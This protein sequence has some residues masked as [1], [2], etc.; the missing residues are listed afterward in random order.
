MR[1]AVIPLCL[2]FDLASNAAFSQ[3]NNEPGSHLH[4]C[5]LMGPTERVECLNKL[6]QSISPPAPASHWT[7]SETISPLDYTP[8]VL[9]VTSSR[10]ASSS[11]QLSLSCRGGRTEFVIAG[12][13]I[14]RTEDYTVSYRINDGGSVTTAVGKPIFGTR[15]AFKTDVV[16]LL[17]SLPDEGYISVR[18]TPR[19]GPAS[20]GQFSLSGSKVVRDKLAA[21][22]KWPQ[23]LAGPRN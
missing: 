18:L 12:L 6:S 14:V 19:T 20:E 2:A 7:I 11:L 23:A 3:S 15:I 4:A 9:A 8:I 10:T 13:G 22:C 5:S 1:M 21:A 17:Q 16:R